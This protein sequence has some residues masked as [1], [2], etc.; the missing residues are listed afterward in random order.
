M[1]ICISVLTSYLPIPTPRPAH[2]KKLSSVTTTSPGS[3]PRRGEGVCTRHPM[4]ERRQ[5]KPKTIYVIRE[6]VGY[7]LYSPKPFVALGFPIATSALRQEVD[8]S[9]V[10]RHFVPELHC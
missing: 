2:R 8:F 9:Q 1:K 10:L 6:S 3:A 5:E 7:R 4:K